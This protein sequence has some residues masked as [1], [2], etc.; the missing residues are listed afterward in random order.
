MDRRNF[1][2]IISAGGA[3]IATAPLLKASDVSKVLIPDALP[4]TNIK[5]I[6]ATPRTK[7]SMPGKYPAKV[8]LCRNENCVIDDTPSE[9]EAYK[10]LT[11]VML[12]LT[13]SR[14]LKKAW[15]KFV[16]PKDIIGLKVNPV[17]DALLSTS[18][19]LTKSVIKQ[20]IEAG[21]PKKN[22]IIWDRRGEDLT[23][24]GF[25]PENYPGI[26]ILSTEFCDEKGSMYDSDGILYGEKNIEKSQYFY[27]DVEEE[28]DIY[29]LPYMVNSGK[30]S[31]LTKIVTEKVT[32][33]INLPILK[34]AGNSIT[35]S[36]KNLAYGS[37]TNTGRLHKLFW[38]HTSAYVCAMPALRDKVVLNIV[39][40]MRG[41]FDGGPAANPQFICN[42]NL[43][44]AGTDP[45]AVDMVGYKHVLQRRIEEGM[46]VK[47]L[48]K[49]YTF[50][51]LG[52]ELGLGEADMG[53]ITILN[54]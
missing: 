15:R 25:T 27:A 9:M 50:A 33:I 37:I 46:N 20:L 10:M 48:P 49:N 14:S 41:C 44:M 5:E 31:Y 19:A 30:Y 22:I 8:A 42:Y 24:A 39:D 34:N 51:T 6:M 17:G 21:I 13:G 18:H 11:S 38:H 1:F 53:K 26:T 47:D 7:D 3:V 28:Y 16:T 23:K 35:L 43:I 40:G 54:V 2:K 29:T 4:E 12:A 45:V 52:A 32:K 36:M